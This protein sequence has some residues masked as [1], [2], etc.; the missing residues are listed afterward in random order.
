MTAH[1]EVDVVAITAPNHLHAEMALSAIDA[2]KAVYCEKPLSTDAA[3]AKVMRDAAV[4][5]GVCTM[6]GF[7]FLR[8]PMVK[9]ARQ[10]IESGELGEVTAFRGIHAEN[11]MADP[12][13]P[14]SFRTDAAGGGGALSDLGSHIISIARYLLG[15]IDSVVG[16]AANHPHQTTN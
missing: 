7:N 3:S 13:V 11:Y 10:I 5:A 9:L 14:H 12:D 2:G 16:S 6:V 8:N 1:P 15:P 4:T